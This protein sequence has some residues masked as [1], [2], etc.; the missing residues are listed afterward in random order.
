MIY[1]FPNPY[2]P[3]KILIL[4]NQSNAVYTSDFTIS[5]H[6]DVDNVSEGAI[7]FAHAHLENR[8]MI[9]SK[10]I[11][12]AWLIFFVCGY[13]LGQDESPPRY[14]EIPIA[15]YFVQEPKKSPTEREKAADLPPKQ[16]E[17]DDTASPRPQPRRDPLPNPES[18]ASGTYALDWPTLVE[19]AKAS[20]IDVT[21]AAAKVHEA[22]AGV[23]LAQK[24]W[25]PSL[26]VGTSWLHHDGYIQQIEGPL[27]NAN[28]NSLYL[29]PLIRGTLDPAAIKRDILKAQQ[30]AC[31]RR[32]HLHRTSQQHFQEVSL[33]FVDL[34]SAQAGAAVLAEAIYLLEDIVN[35]AREFRKAGLMAP[36]NVTVYE[37][38]IKPQIIELEAVLQSH[39]AAGIRLA[40]M[41][42][43]E[44]NA[45]LYV[46][47]EQIPVLQLINVD[48]ADDVLVDAAFR[49]GPGI[50]EAE[51]AIKALQDQ[52]EL[53]CQT[54]FA[55]QIGF[56][57][58]YGAF[59]G[60][61]GNSYRTWGDRT[62]LGVHI[63]WD[64][65]ELLRG[66]ETR[67]LFEAKRHE[68][69]LQR[70]KVQK[71][72]ELGVRVSLDQARIARDRMNHTTQHIANM[73]DLYEKVVNLKVISPPKTNQ[74]SDPSDVQQVIANYTLVAKTI[75]ELAAAR[76]A[77]IKALVDWN[78]AQITLNFLTGACPN[79]SPAASLLGAGLPAP[80]ESPNNGKNGN[81]TPSQEE[82]SEGGSPKNESPKVV[83]KNSTGKAIPSTNVRDSAGGRTIPRAQ[84]KETDAKD[85]GYR[86]TRQKRPRGP[87]PLLPIDE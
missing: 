84:S 29:G 51:L 57:V 16:D 67:N 80:E 24:Q 40:N 14:R 37:N 66:R 4:P 7:A 42:D 56:D 38:Q 13:L 41:L 79:H 70:Q 26:T 27:V 6:C 47:S 35:R 64:L 22:E 61:K 74:D 68:S 63:Y 36:V 11:H 59:G 69:Y 20:G 75:G 43:L 45:R 18:R 28:K 52:L 54:R 72:L 82:D 39:R 17:K 46:A 33:A 1:Y 86:K 31:I 32:A 81:A 8:A 78:K 85:V 87:Y 83:P 9:G 25:I 44:P 5:F 34:Q 58:G 48:V 50:A 15:G 2:I 53:S 65:T 49:F 30:L 10:G 60:G 62:D 71:T 76:G 19:L 23:A 73:I 77:Y 3:S 12:A 55:P 21:I